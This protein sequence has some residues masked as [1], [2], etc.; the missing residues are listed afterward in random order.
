MS[1]AVYSSVIL[2]KS[3]R[4]RLAFIH[5]GDPEQLVWVN[6]VIN[7]IPIAQSPLKLEWGTFIFASHHHVLGNVPVPV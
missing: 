5:K 4:Q 6:G 2:S 7:N 1:V 3:S